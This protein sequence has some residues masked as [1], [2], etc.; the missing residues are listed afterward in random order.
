[1]ARNGNAGGAPWERRVAMLAGQ[2]IHLN[3]TAAEARRSSSAAHP[4]PREALTRLFPLCRAGGAVR[5]PL[6]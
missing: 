6:A 3:N 5:A 1:M 4:P 2:F